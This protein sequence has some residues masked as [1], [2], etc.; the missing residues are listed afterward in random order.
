[1][2]QEKNKEIKLCKNCLK[3]KEEHY[4][5]VEG[6]QRWCYKSC[7]SEEF[8]EDEGEGYLQCPDIDEFCEF[9]EKNHSPQSSVSE[10][11]IAE[12]RET[13]LTSG[14]ATEDCPQENSKNNCL[15]LV[16]GDPLLSELN[17]CLQNQRMEIIKDKKVVVQGYKQSKDITFNLSE[18][19]IIIIDCFNKGIDFKGYPE[20]DV[21]EKIQNAQRRL[22][23]ELK[24]FDDRGLRLDGTYLRLKNKIDKIFQEEFGKDLIGGS[25]NDN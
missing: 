18:K 14:H 15:H 10:D 3:P 25:N 22:K 2:K 21:K 11:S 7:G 8:E 24:E 17:P 9:K 1:M 6:F 23:E 5:D 4:F 16:L 20:E 19:R 13:D 12:G